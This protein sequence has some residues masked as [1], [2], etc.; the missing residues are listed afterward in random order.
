MLTDPVIAADGFT[1]ERKS[2]ESWFKK[3]NM[4]P[5][6]GLALNDTKVIP[7]YAI[8]HTIEQYLEKQQKS[9]LPFPSKKMVS[10]IPQNVNCEFDCLVNDGF[11]YLDCKLVPPSKPEG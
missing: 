5:V 1:Y 10:Y 2:L 4:S 3:S 7:N 6:T 8:K 11:Y 9:G